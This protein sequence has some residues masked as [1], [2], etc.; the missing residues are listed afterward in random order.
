M[1]KLTIPQP[2]GLL[3]EITL[4]PSASTVDKSTRGVGK[5]EIHVLRGKE[6]KIAI[7]EPDY[8]NITS[9]IQSDRDTSQNIKE[10]TNYYDFHTVYLYPSF[11]PDSG[12]EFVWAR[13]GIEL[14]AKTTSGEMIEKPIAWDMKPNEVLSEI[15]YRRDIKTTPGV[16]LSMPLVEA[17]ISHQVSEARQFIVY[18][19][20][21]ISYGIR[22]PN[23]A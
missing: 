19:P 3:F 6:N 20:E 8:E 9:N 17:G 18:E 12:C 2:K 10:L 22:T 16:K 7:G 14:N 13:F 23:P 5:P 15:R 1:V 4:E 21:I 11:L